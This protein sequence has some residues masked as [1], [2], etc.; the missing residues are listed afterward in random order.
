MEIRRRSRRVGRR[1]EVLA[2][3]VSPRTRYQAELL[4]MLHRRSVSEI[5]EAALQRLASLPESS[6]GA[7]LKGQVEVF[8]RNARMGDDEDTDLVTETWDEEEWARRFKLYLLHADALP[9]VER[10]FWL[11]IHRDRSNFEDD[12]VP[13]DIDIEDDIPLTADELIWGKPKLRM[14]RMKREVIRPKWEAFRRK[15]G[16]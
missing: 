1:S 13:D 11:E 5:V 16:T 14:P 2:V 12:G 3:R 6:G 7:T 8:R 15:S 9:P 10:L 4:A